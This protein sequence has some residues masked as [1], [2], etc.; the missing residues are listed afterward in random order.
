MFDRVRETAVV[1][2]LTGRAGVSRTVYMGIL[3]ELRAQ[4]SDAVDQILKNLQEAQVSLPT[5]EEVD[6]ELKEYRY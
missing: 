1:D 4:K 5:P 6:D 3:R 2:V